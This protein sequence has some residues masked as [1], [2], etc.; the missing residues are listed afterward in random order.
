MSVLCE[1]ISEKMS[2]SL[3]TIGNTATADI[4]V[5]VS[6]DMPLI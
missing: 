6:E 5:N 3:H 4:S 1:V 2:H